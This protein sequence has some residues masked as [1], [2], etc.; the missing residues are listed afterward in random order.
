MQYM[1]THQ[2]MFLSIS[3]LLFYWQLEIKW[4]YSCIFFK[5]KA[6]FLCCRYCIWCLKW[7]YKTFKSFLRKQILAWKFFSSV[8]NKILVHIAQIQPV[9]TAGKNIKNSYSF[10]SL[11]AF[12]CDWYIFKHWLQNLVSRDK[13]TEKKV[14]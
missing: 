4:L 2:Q 5:L 9:K 10:L 12:E 8:S 6:L 14:M 11:F 3:G 7:K 1:I 13:S